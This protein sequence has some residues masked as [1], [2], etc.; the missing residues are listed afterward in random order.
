M[1]NTV[2]GYF[3][4]IGKK[5]LENLINFKLIFRD[6]SGDP[7]GPAMNNLENLVQLPTGCG[8]QNMIRFAPLVSV[9]KYLRETAQLNSKVSALAKEYLKIGNYQIHNSLNDTSFN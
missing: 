5:Y 3:S 8:E 2:R 9:T 1:P 7:M 6:T 4:A